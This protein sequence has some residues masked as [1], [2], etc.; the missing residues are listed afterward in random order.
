VNARKADAA[1]RA[2]KSSDQKQPHASTGSDDHIESRWS[3]E[4]RVCDGELAITVKGQHDRLAHGLTK[5][6]ENHPQKRQTW[7]AMT[8]LG[9]VGKEGYE[10]HDQAEEKPSCPHHVG[11]SRDFDAV[12]VEDRI[13]TEDL[14]E[15]TIAKIV[16]ELS[17][18]NAESGA[19]NSGNHQRPPDSYHRPGRFCLR[20]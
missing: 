11:G 15:Q 1:A 16:E 19:E 10:P 4:G 20:C 14:G 6:V 5:D 2:I 3:V 17:D 12:V 8:A 9:R 18:D 13:S 7:D